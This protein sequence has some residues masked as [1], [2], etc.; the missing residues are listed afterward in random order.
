[1]Y[2]IFI[3]FF[4]REGVCYCGCECVPLCFSFFSFEVNLVCPYVLVASEIK[5]KTFSSGVN[6]VCMLFK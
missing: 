5:L 2:V 4:A 1:M 6:E 3:Y